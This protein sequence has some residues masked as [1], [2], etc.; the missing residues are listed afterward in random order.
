MYLAAAEQSPV[1]AKATDALLQL[2]AANIDR[3]YR[4]NS[5]KNS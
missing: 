5:K 4:E 3:L 1:F 2:I